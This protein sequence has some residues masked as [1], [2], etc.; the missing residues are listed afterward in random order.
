MP[1]LEDL[2][3]RHGVSLAAVQTLQDALRR[4]GGRMAQFSHPDL[5]GMGQWSAGGMTQVGDMFNT[6][7]RDRVAALCADLAASA[8]PTANLSPANL[9]PA[10]QASATQASATSPAAMPST[11]PFAAIPP[12]AATHSSW[13]PDGLGQPSATGSQD[14]MRYACFPG[15]RRVAVE[16]AG[17]VTVHDSGGHRIEGVSQAQGATQDLVF[18]S[19]LG[20]VRAIDLPVAG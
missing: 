18:L 4:G 9:S 1:A 10:T 20:R 14:G 11:A 8:V 15:A 17:R 5:G 6:G 16:H 3:T 2:A 12:T 19:Q 13:W 7:L